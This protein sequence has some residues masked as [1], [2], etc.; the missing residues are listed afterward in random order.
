VLSALLLFVGGFLFYAQPLLAAI[1][2]TASPG[3]ES[4]GSAIAVPHLR[5]VLDQ[6]PN[7]ADAS[8]WG[9]TGSAPAFIKIGG[10]SDQIRAVFEIGNSAVASLLSIQQGVEQNAIVISV[11]QYQANQYYPGLIWNTNVYTTD[12]ATKKASPPKLAIWGQMTDTGS[13]MY[14]GTSNSAGNN[15]SATAGITNQALTIDQDGDVGIGSTNPGAKLEVAGNIKMPGRWIVPSSGQWSGDYF[16]VHTSGWDGTSNNNYGGIIGGHGYFY[17][18]LQ[19][20]GNSGNEA[21]SGELYV[22]GKSSLLGSV[23]IGTATPSNKLHVNGS[24]SDNLVR[25]EN[26]STTYNDS[27]IRFRAKDSAGNNAHMDFGIK[28][29]GSEKGNF[30]FKA[31]YSSA[32]RMVITTGGYVGIGTSSP[33]SP[34]QITK[35]AW[36]TVSLEYTGVASLG[37]IANDLNGLNVAT[38]ARWNGSAWVRDDAAKSSFAEIQHLGNSQ[39]EFR[40][41]PPGAG[42]IAWNTAMAIKDTGAVG[43]GTTTPGA[44]LDVAKSGTYGDIYASR[45]GSF[46]A[47]NWGAHG[48]WQLGGG[49]ALDSSLA[50]GNVYLQSSASNEP[51]NL[52]LRNGTVSAKDFCIGTACAASGGFSQWITNGNDISYTK[53][54]VGIGTSSP[55]EKL[56]VAGNISID[57]AAMGYGGTGRSGYGIAFP[58]MSN[59]AQ[60]VYGEHDGADT[61]NLIFHQR[62]N[63]NDGVIFRNTDWNSATNPQTLDYMKISREKLF[64]V[65]GYVGIGTSSPGE[66]LDVAGSI[67]SSGPIYNTSPSGY[68][69]TSLQ[70]WGLSSPGTMYIEPAGGNT[71][72]L[73]DSWSGTGPIRAVADRFSIG[74]DSNTENIS[75]SKTGVLSARSA[76]DSILNLQTTDNAWLYTQWLDKDSKR[77]IWMG[78]DS[79][80]SW[81]NIQP[82]NGTKGVIIGGNVGIGTTSPNSNYKLDVS[83]IINATDIYKNGAPFLPSGVAPVST[84]ASSVKM[85]TNVW[86]RGLYTYQAYSDPNAPTTYGA[87]VGYGAGSSGTGELYQEW[88]DPGRLYHRWLRDCCQNWSGWVRV[89]DTNNDPYPSNMDQ[90]VRTTDSPAFAGLTLGTRTKTREINVNGPGDI[91][92]PLGKFSVGTSIEMRQQAEGGWAETGNKYYLNGFYNS[93]PR[94]TFKTGNSPDRLQF[95]GKI[96]DT[97]TMY[98]W[99]KWINQSPAQ[100]CGGVD[101]GCS[102][103]VRL[104]VTTSSGWNYGD[105]GTF[106]SSA[107]QLADNVAAGYDSLTVNSSSGSMMTLNNT[108]AGEADIVYKNTNGQ[109]EVGTN[110]AGNGTN[111]NHFYIYDDTAGKYDFTVQSGTGNIG[112]GTTSPQD[113]LHVVASG[114]FPNNVPIVAQS[115]STFFGARDDGGNE[116]FAINLDPDGTSYPVNFYDKYDGNWHQDISLKNGNVGIGTSDTQGQRLRI[117]GDLGLPSGDLNLSGAT[118]K[119]QDAPWYG[120]GFNNN[121]NDRWNGNGPIVQLGGYFGLQF[122]EQGATRMAIRGGNVGIG[123]TQPGYKLEVNGPT[124]DWKAKFGGPDGYITIGPANSGWAHIYTDRSNFIFNQDVWSIPGGFSSYSSSDLTLKTNGTPRL[125]IQNSTGNVGIGTQSPGSKLT[126][127]DAG[128]RNAST[129]SASIYS[130][131]GFDTTSQALGNTTLLIQNNS[132]RSGG[133]NELTNTALVAMA[134]GAQKNYA[135]L[136]PSGRVGIGTTTPLA[137]LDVLGMIRATSGVKTSTLCLGLEN[138]SCI[139]KWDQ[140]VPPQPWVISGNNIS[141]TK[142]YT[143]IGTDSPSSVLTVKGWGP[144]GTI[145]IYPTNNDQETSIGFKQYSDGSGTE[146]VMGQN[147][148]GVGSGNFAI[149]GNGSQ[150]LSILSNGNVGIGTPAPTNAFDVYIRKTA[151]FYKKGNIYSVN[152]GNKKCPWD[153]DGHDNSPNQDIIYAGDE[154]LNTWNACSDTITDKYSWPVYQHY[155]VVSDIGPA[156]SFSVTNDSKVGIGTSTPDSALT[157]MGAISGTPVGNGLHFGVDLKQNTAIQLNACATCA[158]YIDFG[159]SGT[160]FDGRI[161]Y[162]NSGSGNA[163]AFNTAGSEKMRITSNGNVG[164]GTSDPQYKLDVRGGDINVGNTAMVTPRE[165]LALANDR[166]GLDVAEIFETNDDVELGDV[167][168]VSADGRR[169]EKT[170]R[171]YD[172]RVIGVVSGSPAVVFEGSDLKIGAKAFRFTKGTKPPIA[173]AGRVPVK[174]S[175]E[176]GEIKPGDFLTTSTTPGVAMKATEGG[177][178]IGIAIEPYSG[179]KENLILVFMNIGER[180]TSEL[181]SAFKDEIGGLKQSVAKLQQRLETVESFSQKNKSMPL[182]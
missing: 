128:A 50:G 29:T 9:G 148:W 165:K 118:D 8:Q 37:R 115:K 157:I 84:G 59:D 110:Q 112:I 117:D 174:V 10:Y 175:L 182:W 98:L 36:D 155:A 71:L 58:A 129:T 101:K 177:A 40:V 67:R 33:L 127:V 82:E 61:S 172:A 96:I 81:F 26:D 139:S 123:T 106:D 107:T 3:Q 64:Y 164:I 147:S 161:L 150:K 30:Y 152:Y 149:G 113:K 28:A 60:Y 83:G 126:V 143:G 173:L 142:G 99:A 121:T 138:S 141:Y 62:D 105:Q 151:H 135:I 78:L 15:T 168:I 5:E 103:S 153:I 22:A 56:S 34:L 74:P 179:G 6:G 63:A 44:G 93:L 144:G 23:G 32:D 80:L 12:P 79:D 17:G 120:I 171:A 91:V 13:K 92:I 124:N 25:F 53:G 146:W 132:S 47:G 75:L 163:M 156:P 52:V 68:A 65:G 122:A 72:W 159:Q 11:P 70:S 31:P 158:S 109:W 66:R 133:S 114:G 19:S 51:A 89:L 130:G 181:I 69:Q 87:V 86:S 160:D 167:L 166:V 119:Y 88:T 85:N 77:R 27:S 178:T 90:Y 7:K 136:V 46:F 35:S 43:I 154:P 176:N 24:P 145:R 131:S 14:F 57:G 42:N 41:S 95:Y 162:F 54:N 140:I 125:T 180:N 97:S 170:S 111:N 134:S 49:T 104:Q 45:S 116:R 18:G 38:N 1:E 2:P 39:I 73:T 169:L 76:T 21:A 55:T 48:V 102:N 108:G 4:P 137:D 20:G 100:Y 94:V 16:E